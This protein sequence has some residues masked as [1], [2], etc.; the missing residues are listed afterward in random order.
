MA[1]ERYPV[2][3]INRRAEWLSLRAHDL[4]ASDVG[5]WLGVDPYRTPFA[6]VAQKLGI[7]Q[8]IETGLM[9]R[10]RWLESASLIALAERY[11]TWDIRPA[12]IYCRDTEVRLGA[13]PDA[14]AEDPG[15]PGLV[16]VQVK[17]VT[18]PSFEQ[19]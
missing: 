14:I 2:D 9:R 12:G 13:T 7:E 8:V 19:H 5:A 6:V 18:R 1:I 10:G 11:P 16:A 4:T 17:V 3:P 15:E